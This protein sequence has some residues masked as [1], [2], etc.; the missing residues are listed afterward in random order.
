MK[1]IKRVRKPHGRVFIYLARPGRKL[2]RLPDLPENHPAFIA[3]YSAAWEAAE[4]PVTRPAEGTVSALAAQWRESHEFRNLSSLTRQNKA[5]ILK[6]L[7]ARVGHVKVAEIQPHHIARDLEKQAGPHAANNLLKVW[8]SLMRYARKHDARPD[9]PAAEVDRVA[10][11]KTRGLRTWTA[12]EIETFKKRHPSGSMAR[13]ALYLLLFLGRRRSEVTTL[14]RQHVEDG[15]IWIRQPKTDRSDD[16]RIWVPL[17][18]DLAAEIALAKDRMTFLT[19]STGR[20]FASGN[21]FANWWRDRAEEAGLKGWGTHGG[22]KAVAT[23]LAESSATSQQIMSITGHRTLAEVERYTA[24][25]AQR[26]MAREGM[27]RLISGNRTAPVSKIGE[28]PNE[29][30]AEN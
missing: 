21:S 8:R 9:D 11:R 6:R 16:D 13:L 5:A 27:D 23:F 15:G 18:P 14:G 29:N 1:H 7:E 30:K 17:H 12:A 20:P 4:R 19:S 3:A 10:V 28:K 22:R 26:R 24:A 2:V 25:A